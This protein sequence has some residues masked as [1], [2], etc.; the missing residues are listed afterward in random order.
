MSKTQTIVESTYKKLINDER[1]LRLLHYP[2]ENFVDNTPP[3]I[4][5]KLPDILKKSE[6]EY[7][8]IV[9]EHVYRRTKADDLQN[10]KICRI[11]IY[12]GN[13]KTT[14][15]MRVSKREIV[16]D[17]FCNHDYEVDYRIES[18][19]DRLSEL[20][21]LKRIEGGMGV[22]EYKNGYEFVAPNGY[23][24]YRHIYVVGE[25]K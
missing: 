16:I 9:D 24:A 4:S 5:D 7:W 3:P 1:L 22:I 17:V 14:R 10:K 2:P 19:A 21:F 23:E 12:A 13:K 8:Q 15:N 6:K 18:I 25:T 20:L 11:Y